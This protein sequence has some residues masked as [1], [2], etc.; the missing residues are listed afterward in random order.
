MAEN[1]VQYQRGLPMLEFFETYGTQEQCEAVVRQWRWPEGFI[2]PRCAQSWHSEFRRSGRL[3]FQCS[4]C[5]YQC[6]LASGTIFESTKLALP[7]WF[8]AMH[9]ITQAKN[10]VSALELM[11]HIG[12]TYPTA[13]L[14]K[15]KIM[16]VM[17]QRELPRQLSGRVE[18][19]DAYL[20]GELHGGKAGRGS[21]NKVAFVAAVQTTEG[22]EPVF[23][24]LSK[25][26]FT[27][28]SIEAF[29]ARSLA[30]PLTLVSDGLSCFSAVQS[31]GIRHERHVTGGGAAS[32]SHPS[33]LAI[34]TLLGNLKT[35]LSGTYHAFGFEKYADRYLAQVQYLFNRRFDLSAILRRLA[36]AACR[37]G[38]CPL[39]TIR[40]AEFPC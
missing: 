36:I 11:R 16:E 34:N 20:G 24:C 1:G 7:K 5:R 23:M 30:L 25:R 4:S 29:A 9:L 39:H 14:M 33:F 18:V 17:R 12:V 40:T 26:P 22:G 28:E 6:S 13:W 27:K 21:P 15:H 10:N 32:V 31:M 38:R 3:Y 37:T 2:C 8:V 35:S 19:D